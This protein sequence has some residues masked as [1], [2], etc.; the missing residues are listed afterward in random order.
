MGLKLNFNGTCTGSWDIHSVLLA[1]A[2]LYNWF[3]SFSMKLFNSMLQRINDIL[4][5]SIGISMGFYGDLMG[6]EWI[7]GISPTYL[8]WRLTC[9]LPP[10][11]LCPVVTEVVTHSLRHQVWMYNDVD[12]VR[13]VHTHTSYV[14]ACIPKIPK[15]I[16]I[17]QHSKTGHKIM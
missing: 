10:G 17:T 8:G 7:H 9:L 4:V 3:V 16:I 6:F 2:D 14:H 13:K 5:E 11:T 12:M 1:L 15:H